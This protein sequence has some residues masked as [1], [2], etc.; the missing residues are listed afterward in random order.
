M[1][2][3]P[4]IP[5]QRFNDAA[6][7]LAHVRAIYDQSIGWMRDVF[8]QFVAGENLQGHVRATYPFVRIHSSTVGRA[9]SRLSYGFL[10]GPGTYETTLTR[11]DMFGPYYAEMFRLLLA[12]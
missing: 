8:R 5:P 12:S 7:A 6:A 11:P 4:F 10:P 9:D 3:P 1:L 2:T